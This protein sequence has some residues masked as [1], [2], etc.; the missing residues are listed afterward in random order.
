MVPGRLAFGKKGTVYVT[1]GVWNYRG[2]DVTSGCNLDSTEGL[3][4]HAAMGPLGKCFTPT[5]LWKG[6]V[7]QNAMAVK[8]AGA[9]RAPAESVPF[10][11]G[12]YIGQPVDNF[13]NIGPQ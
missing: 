1:T 10:V 2:A 4:V 5:A 3:T 7:R 9:G 13:M 11:P 12:K 8:A 6:V